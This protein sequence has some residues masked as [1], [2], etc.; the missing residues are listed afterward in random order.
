MQKRTKYETNSLRLPLDKSDSRSAS[1][2]TRLTAARK[3]KS[4]IPVGMTEQKEEKTEN[5]G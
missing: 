5:T 4:A 1:W 3:K 2:P